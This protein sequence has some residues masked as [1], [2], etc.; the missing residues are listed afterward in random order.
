MRWG[1][2]DDLAALVKL[3]DFDVWLPASGENEIVNF[4]SLIGD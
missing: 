1:S 3:G 2:D 4:R